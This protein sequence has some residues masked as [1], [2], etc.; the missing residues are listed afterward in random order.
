LAPAPGRIEL[1]NFLL[2]KKKDLKF[3]VPNVRISRTDPLDII[4]R[5]LNMTPAERSR[6]R[7]NKSTLWYQRKKLASGQKIKVYSKSVEK[8]RNITQ[9][10]G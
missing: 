2:D 5:I 9:P 10:A 6:L 4:E 3:N 7:I 8:L 1:A